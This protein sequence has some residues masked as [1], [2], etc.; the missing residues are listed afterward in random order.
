MQHKQDV[1]EAEK[2]ELINQVKSIS[3]I[4]LENRPAT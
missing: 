4:F 2:E 1:L 3:P